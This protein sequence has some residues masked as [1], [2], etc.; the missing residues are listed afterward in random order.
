MRGISSNQAQ[1]RNIKKV[2]MREIPGKR[3]AN[4]SHLRTARISYQPVGGRRSRHT[5]DSTAH[6]CLPLQRADRP[7]S[8]AGR[9]D[10][11]HHQAEQRLRRLWLPCSMRPMRQSAAGPVARRELRDAGASGR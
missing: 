10:R 6:V 3:V 4:K 2:I 1:L 5:G 11:R 9:R 7:P 8:E